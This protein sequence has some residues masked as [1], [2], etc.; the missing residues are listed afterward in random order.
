MRLQHAHESY[1]DVPEDPLFLLAHRMNL[2]TRNRSTSRRIENFS[3]LADCSRRIICHQRQDI[4]SENIGYTSCR[5]CQQ[6]IVKHPSDCNDIRI[7]ILKLDAKSLVAFAQ[8]TFCKIHDGV[9][10]RLLHRP[11]RIE[12]LRPPAAWVHIAA[13]MS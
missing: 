8:L 11:F 4:L 13:S 9:M 12:G 10:N 5:I 2:S 1:R 6:S 7:S 3:Q